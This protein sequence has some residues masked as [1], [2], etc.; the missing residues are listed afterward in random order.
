MAIM[1]G[2]LSLTQMQE[3]CGFEFP[4]EAL[5]ILSDNRQEEVNHKEIKDGKWHCF[6]IPF[7]IMVSTKARAEQLRDILSPYAEQFK[8]PLQIAW[9]RGEENE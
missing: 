2:N 4:Q 8:V 3:R 7:L 1:L 6:D 9:E 5:A